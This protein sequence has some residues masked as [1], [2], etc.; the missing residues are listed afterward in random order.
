MTTAFKL[1]LPIDIPWSRVCV[2][3]DMVDRAVCDRSLPPKWHSSIAV[4]KFRP[5]D[6]YQLYPDYDITYLKVSCTIT[7]YQPLEDEI[8]GSIDWDGLD[9]TTLEGVTELLSSYFP[10]TGAILQVAVGPSSERNAP[11]LDQYPFFMDFEPKK[12]ELYEMATDTKE[13]QSRS[14]ESVTVGKSAGST[15]SVEVLDVDMGGSTSV[16]AEGSYAGTG[17]GF[18]YSSSNQG[19][20]GTKALNSDTS[21]TTRSTEM[22][23]ERR[24]TQAFTTQ[25]SQMYHLLDSYHAGTNRAV[26]FVQPR[27]HVLE[28]PTGFVRGPRKIEGIQ[29]FFLVVAAPKD[30]PDYCVSARLD[31]AHLAETDVLDYETRTDISDLASAAARIPTKNDTPA[32][33]TTRE[34]CFFTCW[35]VTYLCYRTNDVDD[36][37]YQAPAG[38]EI[39]GWTD[40]VNQSDGHGSSSVSL[41]SDRRVLTVHAEADGHIC[42]EDS[43]V[44]VDCP[45]EVDKWTGS[46][47]R[48]VQVQLRSLEPTRV[49]GTRTSLLLTTRGLCCCGD[50]AVRP[51]DWGVYIA[52][53]P[54]HLSVL[55]LDSAI[56]SFAVGRQVARQTAATAV[57]A[58]APGMVT[59]P[60]TTAGHTA[61]APMTAAR[62]MT[63]AY[64][65][66][67]RDCG[68]GPRAAGASAPAV[69]PPA[70]SATA[71]M[72]TPAVSVRRANAIADAARAE[73]TKR[74]TTASLRPWSAS[75]VETDLFAKQLEGVVGRT[76][77]GREQL[78][79]RAELPDALAKVLATRLN[80]PPEELTRRDLLR[81]RAEELAQETG[82]EVADLRRARLAALGATV[83][84]KRSAPPQPRGPQPA[85]RAATETR[86]ESPASEDEQGDGPATAE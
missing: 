59:A 49:V 79:A 14:I 68:C 64:G 18:T 81:F 65:L 7:G 32:G 60:A 9:V 34:A 77:L 72:L 56:T 3:E 50:A 67:E 12:R 57:V 17:G 46:A 69:P 35:D 39:T 45:D 85:P 11:P 28:E 37:V 86:D 78:G 21:Q 24:E 43:G 58:G 29:E 23:T 83:R 53:L 20:W 15:S 48:Q 62:A 33:T 4:F 61:A 1:G 44:C 73:L 75:F 38:F 52:D 63:T 16:G 22:G 40:L 47:R 82:I 6:E 54:R 5:E 27:P 42:F 84:R 31:T 8:Q 36:V 19:Q 41:S 55:P 70:A 26:F 25:L 66:A 10:C 74:L 30:S 76:R 13:K 80:R 2:T 71:A 51:L